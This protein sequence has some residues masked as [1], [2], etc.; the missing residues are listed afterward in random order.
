MEKS[1]M[2]NLEKAKFLLVSFFSVGIRN[3]RAACITN[4]ETHDTPYKR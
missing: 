4:Y 3:A 2:R 1:C